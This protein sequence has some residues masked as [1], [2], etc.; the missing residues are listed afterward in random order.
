MQVASTAHISSGGVNSA[1]LPYGIN[2]ARKSCATT[3]CFRPSPHFTSANPEPEYSVSGPSWSSCSAS[4]RSNGSLPISIKQTNAQATNASSVAVGELQPCAR[5]ALIVPI[6]VE[7]AI[8][9]TTSSARISV[10]STKMPI[11]S[12]RLA[13]IP[14][15]VLPVSSPESEKKKRNS[16]NRYSSV[17]KSPAPPNGDI[18][19][20]IGNVIATSS[21]D[22]SST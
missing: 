22:P 7:P 10:G 8:S 11:T 5:V 2:T 3:T 15:K 18:R 12:S 9:A 17:I 19:V 21:I 20:K 1:A 14:A 6:L 4:A 16:A 13:P